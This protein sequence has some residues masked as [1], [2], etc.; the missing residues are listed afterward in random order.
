M[1]TKKTTKTTKAKT[2][3]NETKSKLHGFVGRKFIQ[4]SPHA[5]DSIAK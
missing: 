5:Q 4:I 1:K 3:A 2:E